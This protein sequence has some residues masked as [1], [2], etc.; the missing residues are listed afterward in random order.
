MAFYAPLNHDH[1]GVCVYVL[2]SCCSVIFFHLSLFFTCR[3][4]L[5]KTKQS[6]FDW[7]K[8]GGGGG[9]K[10]NGPLNE[11]VIHHTSHIYRSVGLGMGCLELRCI[12]WM[13]GWMFFCSENETCLIHKLTHDLTSKNEWMMNEIVFDNVVRWGRNRI[14][15]QKKIITFKCLLV[16]HFRHIFGSKKFFFRFCCCCCLFTLLYLPW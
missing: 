13:D 16:T 3:Q 5:T 15:F 8:G 7:K 11:T 14:E 6:M 12:G 4:R 1:T 10:K 2:V 9:W